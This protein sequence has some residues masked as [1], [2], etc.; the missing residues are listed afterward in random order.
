M[1][2]QHKCI[3]CSKVLS[4]R[5]NLHRHTK[6]FCKGRNHDSMDQ[7][8]DSPGA[9][10]FKIANFLD[11]II[12]NKDTS[13]S[14]PSLEPIQTPT[15]LKKKVK[16]QNKIFDLTAK[17]K[18]TVDNGED[19]DDNGNHNHHPKS[20]KHVYGKLVDSDDNINVLSPP[21]SCEDM[22][23]DEDEDDDDSNNGDNYDDDDDDDDS[24]VDGDD[25]M[26]IDDSD[27]SDKS[28]NEK[29]DQQLKNGEEEEEEL[30]ENEK[31]QR[32]IWKDIKSTAN[33]LVRH[34]YKKVQ[35]ILQQFPKEE[36]VLKERV[37]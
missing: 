6:M 37:R 25:V 26:V 21:Q 14:T 9:K 27:N 12:N 11:N 18:N 31:L 22:D 8:D 24:D 17:V 29:D 4:N 23:A 15:T 28:D 7:N 34:D 19:D 20:L 10:K 16:Y 5:H 13:P 30:S 35:K 33:Y 36:I 1:D 3:K 2:K 32:Q